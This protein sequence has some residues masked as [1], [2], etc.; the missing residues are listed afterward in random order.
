MRQLFLHAGL[1]KTGTTYL[2]KLF[3]RNR[4]ALA[5]AGLG[6][7]PHQDAETGSHYPRFVE[8]VEAR[9][10]AAVLDETEACPGERLL[11]SNE[12]LAHF[13]LTPLPSGNS[14][15]WAEEIRDA[16]AGRFAVTVIVYLRRQDFLRE[17]IFAQVVKEWHCGD[18]LGQD[19]YDYDLNGKLLQLEAVF[20]R[21]RVR[22]ILYDDTGRVDLVAP[23]LAAL[24]LAVDAAALAP[25]AR[26]NAAL[27]RRKVLFLSRFPKRPAARERLED[28]FPSRFVTRVLAGSD[29]VADDGGRFLM[30]PAARHA[31]VAAH[32]DGNRALVARHGI[33]DPGGFVALP[34]PAAPWTP[35]AP[36][37]PREVA[38]VWRESLAAC[39]EDR[40]PLR[41]AWL[42]ARLSRPF[43]AM[44]ARSRRGAT[45]RAAC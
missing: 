38:A 19:H 23:F 37:T 21:A 42:A 12:D 44:M 22:P 31:L 33:A 28:K 29:A 15:T 20:G 45:L 39:G 4:E 43:A 41:A 27:H 40:D 6:F 2:Q 26:E 17:S 16:A 14:R 13:L 30:P 1:P 11:V 34:D 5:G 8:A 25:V 3:L 10:A 24:G 18:I 35:P 7:G 9:G 36:V 32:L